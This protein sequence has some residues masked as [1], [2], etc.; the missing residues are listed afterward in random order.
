MAKEL[1]TLEVAQNEVKEWLEYRKISA[2]KVESLK[3]SVE[4][5][6]NAIADGD[7]ELNEDK[8]FKQ[9]LKFPIEGESGKIETLVFQ[10]RLK[11]ATV[12]AH[13]QSVKST[14]LNGMV[15]AY[16]AALTGKPKALITSLDSTD[17]SIARSIALFFL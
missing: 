5:L 1:V 13:L 6:A 9:N 4:E 7:I 15:V 14:D 17:Y 16:I 10:P 3:D 2:S 11:I 8:S 12:N